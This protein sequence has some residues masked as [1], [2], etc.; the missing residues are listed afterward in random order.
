MLATLKRNFCGKSLRGVFISF[1]QNIK[2][3]LQRKLCARIY[4]GGK[5]NL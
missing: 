5:K 2:I 1:K 4:A 3:T